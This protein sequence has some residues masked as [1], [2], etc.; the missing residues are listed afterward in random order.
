MFLFLIARSG[1]QMDGNMRKILS[2]SFDVIQ[3][4]TFEMLFVKALKMFLLLP[5]IL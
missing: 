5:R 2:S 3:S 4:S 1:I